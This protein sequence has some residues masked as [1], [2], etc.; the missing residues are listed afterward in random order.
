[1]PF[2]DTNDLQSQVPRQ[3]STVER[4]L[5]RI[6]VEDLNLKLL[7]LAITFV[8]W[9]A[10]TGQK[11]PTTKRFAGV[12]LSFVLADGMQISNDPPAQVDVTL[13]GSSDKLAQIN[14]VD[15]AATVLVSDYKTG[16]R[17]VRLSGDRVK[18]DLP[19]GVR[20]EG[21]QPATVSVRL[22]P[23]VER[24]VD[25]DVKLEGNVG[26]GYEV[27]AVS[28]NP[29]KVRLRGPGSHVNTIGKAPTE[30]ISLDGRKGSFELAEVAIDIADQKVDVMDAVV[31]V[32][33]EIGERSVERVFNDVRVKSASGADAR[34]RV[35]SVTLLG[36]PSAFALL[37]PEDV[38]VVVD[39]S[40]GS[41]S[42][43][44]ELPPAIQGRVKLRSIKP[45]SFSVAR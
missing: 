44:L 7:S 1:M 28:S 22:E 8:L 25:V 2:Q 38:K 9:F 36:P 39:T 27:Y 29:A 34:P 4:W 6:F 15:L 42:P 40:P 12:R 37:R 31:G 45:S 26:E 21:F 3:P 20:I 33:V 43:R 14:Q 17:V 41:N 24:Q 13:T 18:M 5:R 19:E 16:D 35:A 23:R 10:V 32:H 30:S 11:K